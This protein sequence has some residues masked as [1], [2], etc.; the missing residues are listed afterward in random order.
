MIGDV[1]HRLEVE[2]GQGIPYRIYD[3]PWSRS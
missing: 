3:L 2:R 1:V